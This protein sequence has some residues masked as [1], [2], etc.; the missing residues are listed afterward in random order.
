MKVKSSNNANKKHVYRVQVLD[1]IMAILGCFTHENPE[2]TFAD[3]LRQVKLDKSTLYR[4]LEALR[5]HDVIAADRVNGKY[6]LGMRLFELGTISIDRL[7]VSQLAMPALEWLVDQTGETAHLCVLDRSEVLYIA[8]VESRLPFHIPSNIGRR[9]LA[10]CTAVG[11]ALLAYL[12]EQRLDEYLSNTPLRKFTENTITSHA[13][14]K[15]RL[16]QI[17]S[18]GFSTD[19]QEME[20]GL[21]CIGAPVRDHSATVVAAISLAG[22]ATRVTKK[23]RA[24]LAAYVMV[25]AGRVSASLGFSA[26]K[27]KT[28]LSSSE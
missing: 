1:R 25:A 19:N 23:N 22:P 28:L 15:K 21:R 2:R 27:R 24:E 4:L 20:E 13:E 5:S 18:R 14:L 11:K 12:P 8:K 10:Y 7:E 26:V 6:S 9:N 16:A 3:I 17:R